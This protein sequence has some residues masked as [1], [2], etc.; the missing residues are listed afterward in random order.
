MFCAP[1]LVFNGTAASALVF[2]FCAPELI[3]DGTDGV[4]YRFH[5]YRSRAHFRQC[6]GCRVPFSCFALPDMF[7]AVPRA[8]GPVFMFCVPRHIFGGAEGIGSYFNDLRCWTRFHRY[9]GS[10]LQFSCF[11]L[12]NLL[13]ALSRVSSPVFMFC[14]SRLVFGGNEGVDS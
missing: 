3:F 13:S 11:R 1:K 2:M 10:R 6:G 12:P 4:G 7:S 14:A 9:R 5:V 8:S